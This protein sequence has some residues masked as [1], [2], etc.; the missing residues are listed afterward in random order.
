MRH[1]MNKSVS[2]E[3]D[4]RTIADFGAQWTHFRENPGFYG[5][6]EMLED[7]LQP[8]LPLSEI[9]GRRVC[10]IGSGSGRIVNMLLDAGAAHVI[11]IEPSQAERI[12]RLNTAPRAERIT[13]LRATGDQLPLA[14]PL[15]IVVSIGVL[16]HV[17][18]PDPIVARAWQALKPGGRI[19]VWLY[20]REGNEL[21]LRFALPLRALTRRMPDVALR[22]FTHLLT[23]PLFGYVSMCRILPLPMRS[24][25]LSVLGR[26]SYGPLWL[27]IF[28]QL[29]TTY[30]TYYRR[31]EAL[32]LLE[33]AGFNDV[34]W[35]HRHGY[36]WTVVGRKPI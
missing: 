15:D 28:D 14:P 7:I 30:S 9:V 22:A 26:Y 2:N 29:N 35:R 31:D 20:A 36:S 21:Y 25:M 6:V 18:D 19:A 1:A 34:L 24:Y 17:L 32:S 33:R 10:E 23:P 13:Y 4:R 3:I 27:T 16:H 8:L 12:L 11:A 5:S